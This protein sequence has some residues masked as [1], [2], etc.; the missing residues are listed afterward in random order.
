[1]RT[2]PGEGSTFA[3]ALP[4][5]QD[6]AGGAEDP[7]S[8]P[9]PADEDACILYIEDNPANLMLVERILASGRP[10]RLVSAMQ[11]GL[12]LE[13]AR[14]LRPHLVLLDMHLPDVPGDRVLAALRE[15][16]RTSGI[17]V[18]VVSAD[19]TPKRIEELLAAGAR[20][21]VT[22]P[23]DVERLLAVLE[24]VLPVGSGAR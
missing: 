18:V 4:V 2:A 19:A 8:S 10:V 16:P 9:A 23:F 20:D 12:G 24:A 11:G 22:K 6:P 3:F 14:S 15:D 5:A 21:Y 7:A 13:M 17:P 1:M